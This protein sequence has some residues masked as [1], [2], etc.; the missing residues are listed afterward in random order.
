[1]AGF[2][3]I[4]LRFLRL[5]RYGF[6]KSEDKVLERVLERRD[7]KYI[8]E[9]GVPRVEAPRLP[10]RAPPEAAYGLGRLDREHATR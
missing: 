9:V 5:G 3:N 2:L 1:M 7:Y 6:E 4:I 10:P 8:M